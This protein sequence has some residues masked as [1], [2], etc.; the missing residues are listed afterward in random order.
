MAIFESNELDKIINYACIHG[1]M[2]DGDEYSLYFETIN[3][4]LIAVAPYGVV[5]YDGETI[6]KV[7]EQLEVPKYLYDDIMNTVAGLP[8]KLEVKLDEE[9]AAY[10]HEQIK[11]IE[12]NRK[13]CRIIRDSVD[14]HAY[15]GVGEDVL[16]YDFVYLPLRRTLAI[17]KQE[18][19]VDSWL[20]VKSDENGDVYYTSGNMSPEH[21]TRYALRKYKRYWDSA[22]TGML[23]LW[24]RAN[25]EYDSDR[26]DYEVS[27]NKWVIRFFHNT[28]YA[29]N[30]T[31]HH[32]DLHKISQ[33][34]GVDGWVKYELV[35]WLGGFTPITDCDYIRT[36]QHLFHDY[37]RGRTQDT[38][39][40]NG[41]IWYTD[42][43]F[44]GDNC[45]YFNEYDAGWIKHGDS[46]LV[47]YRNAEDELIV[48]SK[49]DTDFRELIEEHSNLFPKSSN[50]T[51][52]SLG[53]ILVLACKK[54][55]AIDLR[56][57][58]EVTG[59]ILKHHFSPEQISEL[60]TDITGNYL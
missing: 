18:Q 14:I 41:I 10:I 35:N 5:R 27:S 42:T 24:G 53:E 9:K 16:D 33:V 12:G 26:A 49:G 37:V 54:A 30:I 20:L 7:D 22:T 46:E 50:M 11:N 19:N 3:K 45:V 21:D 43:F 51:T 55:N 1:N 36:A 40:Y 2:R 13:C 38:A 17:V 15:V 23:Y 39:M 4:H 57:S 58:C 56:K 31:Y 28:I 47:M 8:S 32:T 25:S 60:I 6:C 29:G 52:M 59:N 48:A 44:Y 34:D